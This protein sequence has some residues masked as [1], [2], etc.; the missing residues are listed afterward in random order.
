MPHLDTERDLD[1]PDDVF[2]RLTELHSRRSGG[3]EPSH[4]RKAGRA[5]VQSYW[6]SS[7]IR[8]AMAF[9]EAD[10]GGNGASCELNAKE[11]SSL[12]IVARFSQ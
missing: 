2:E 5:S 6:G 8:M 10:A 3:R 1:W 9:A 11:Q 7:V 4:Q 12:W